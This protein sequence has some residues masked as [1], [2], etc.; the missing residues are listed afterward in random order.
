M[1]FFT[2]GNVKKR[3]FGVFPKPGCLGEGV[4]PGFLPEPVSPAAFRPEPVSGMPCGFYLFKALFNIDD[5]E[6]G[7]SI[8]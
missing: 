4:F 7:R 1:V 2:G 6:T 8:F 3:N 5:R